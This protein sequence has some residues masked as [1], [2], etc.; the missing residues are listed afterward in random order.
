M[1]ANL[2]FQLILVIVSCYSI[3][4][5]QSGEFFKYIRKIV[6]LQFIFMV[7]VVS[8][9]SFAVITKIVYCNDDSPYRVENVCY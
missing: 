9:P 2:L 4:N 3:I 6:N 8:G 1:L 7:K 5:N